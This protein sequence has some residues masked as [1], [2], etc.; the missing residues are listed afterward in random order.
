MWRKACLAFARRRSAPAPFEGRAGVYFFSSASAA[1]G[2]S[3]RVGA[4]LCV[5]VV[6]WRGGARFRL[7]HA[8]PR[9]A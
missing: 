4:C 7:L 1:G 8:Q 5:G 9:G 3:G 6:A 2:S